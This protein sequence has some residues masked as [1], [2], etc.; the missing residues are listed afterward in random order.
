MRII[1]ANPHAEIS[2]HRKR[3]GKN[4]VIFGSPS[5]VRSPGERLKDEL[6]SVLKFRDPRRKNSFVQGS[7]RPNEAEIDDEQTVFSSGV[8][9]VHYGVQR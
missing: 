6:T 5:A 1:G 9:G 4:I 2:A 8:I 3:P 7:E